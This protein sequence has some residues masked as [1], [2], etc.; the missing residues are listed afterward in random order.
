M[1]KKIITALGVN[2]LN[3]KLKEQDNVEVIGNDIPYQDGVL[4]ILKGNSEINVLILHE[5]LVGEFEIKF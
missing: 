5:N 1:I 4:D 3:S 2:S